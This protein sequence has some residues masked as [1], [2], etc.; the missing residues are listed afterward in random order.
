L[1]ANGAVNSIIDGGRGKSDI[2]RINADDEYH[3]EIEAP[4]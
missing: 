4:P 1:T 2:W 3:E